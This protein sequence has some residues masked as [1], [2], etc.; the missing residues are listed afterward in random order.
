M[1]GAISWLDVVDV[2]EA[3]DPRFPEFPVDSDNDCMSLGWRL[4][5]GACLEIQKNE[6]ENMKQTKLFYSADTDTGRT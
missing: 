4:I 2:V 6:I 1:T 5:R 3:V